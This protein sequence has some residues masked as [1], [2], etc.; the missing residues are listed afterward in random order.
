MCVTNLHWLVAKQS[1]VGQLCFN[2]NMMK[3]SPT[4]CY[5]KCWE[6]QGTFYFPQKDISVKVS[7]TI[8]VYS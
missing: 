5:F 2:V 1:W 7:T 6:S 4:S 8:V 3:L